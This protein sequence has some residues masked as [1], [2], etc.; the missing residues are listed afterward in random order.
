MSSQPL[1]FFTD[2]QGRSALAPLPPTSILSCSLAV[3]TNTIA[4]VPSESGIKEYLVCFSNNQV[5]MAINNT[6]AAPAGASFAVTNTFKGYAQ[7]TLK[8]GDEI[9][10]LNDGADTVDIYIAF[11]PQA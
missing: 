6:A 8:P 3:D 1:L 10:M 9:N 5:L 11:F 7:L 4:T 2:V